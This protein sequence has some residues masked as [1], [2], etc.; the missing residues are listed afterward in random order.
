MINK[1]QQKISNFLNY[2]IELNLLSMKIGIKEEVKNL[3]IKGIEESYYV[4]VEFMEIAGESP[5]LKHILQ[6]E[7]YWACICGELVILLVYTEI[8][9]NIL[10]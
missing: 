3:L 9:L 7:K 8:I 6:K 2:D 1:I 10:E 4:D 5:T